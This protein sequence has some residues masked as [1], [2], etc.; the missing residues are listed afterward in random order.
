VE[1]EVPLER[2]ARGGGD[3]Y[4]RLAVRLPERPGAE[5]RALWQKLRAPRLSR[6]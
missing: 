6:S 1:L 3:L 2:I 4:L 5:E